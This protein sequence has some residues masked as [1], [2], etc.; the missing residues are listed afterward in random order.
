MDRNDENKI[1]LSEEILYKYLIDNNIQYHIDTNIKY[2]GV[3]GRVKNNYCYHEDNYY[4]KFF[5]KH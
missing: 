4:F 3:N 2:S 1:V 5:S